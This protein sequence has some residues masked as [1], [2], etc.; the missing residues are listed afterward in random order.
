MK[1]NSKVYLLILI[2]L[3]ILSIS[4]CSSSKHRAEE[5]N[6]DRID[7]LRAE[8]LIIED[9]LLYNWNVMIHDDN[10]RLS[11][12]SRLIDELIYANAFDSTY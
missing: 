6:F 11:D 9:T 10:E 8:L 5:T 1:N 4:S 7:S 3:T 2:T 12:M